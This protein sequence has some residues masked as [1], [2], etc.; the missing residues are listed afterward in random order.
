MTS[1][2]KLDFGFDPE[3]LKEDL[4]QVRPEEWVGHF[5][6]KYFEGEWVGIALRSIGGAAGRLYSNPDATEPYADTPILDRCPNV[7]H[8]LKTFSCPLRSVRFLKLG[9]AAVIREHR[10]YD[11]GFEF[12]LVRLHIPILTNDRVDFFLD[13]GK[14]MMQ[15]GECWYLDLSLP[16]WVEN[17]GSTAR[18]HLVIDCELNDWLR[19]LLPSPDDKANPNTKSTYESSPEEL[20]RFREIVRSDLSLQGRLRQTA[21][22]ESFIRLVANIGHERG[23]KF[24]TS[25][26]EEALRAAHQ[27]LL[28]T[29]ID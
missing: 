8:L 19:R 23:Y 2:W 21:D 10:D 24:T 26:A 17:H 28:E 16:H 20:E 4:A 29:W 12:G 25:D 14:L 22:W 9:P 15:P 1:S 5:N 7:R 13:A 3:P 6:T 18:V 11:F 27:S